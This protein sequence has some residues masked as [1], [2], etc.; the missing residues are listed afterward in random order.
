MKRQEEMTLFFILRGKI[1]ISRYADKHWLCG[2][3]IDFS[4][5]TDKKNLLLSV[6]IITT[7]AATKENINI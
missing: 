7:F 1:V 6:C 2:M 4:L 5:C 3:L